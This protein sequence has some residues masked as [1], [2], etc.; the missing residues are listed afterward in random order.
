MR[1]TVDRITNYLDLVKKKGGKVLV[2]QCGRRKVVYN[3]ISFLTG[4]PTYAATDAVTIPLDARQRLLLAL[5]AKYA[6]SDPTL[7]DLNCVAMQKRPLT[8]T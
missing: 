3:A 1:V 5:S 6:T 7:A 8:P 4:Y 2:V